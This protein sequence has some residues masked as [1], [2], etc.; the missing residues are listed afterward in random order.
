MVYSFTVVC[1]AVVQCIFVVVVAFA[2]S[3]ALYGMRTS[4]RALQQQLD[5]RFAVMLPL[6]CI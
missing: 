1:G 6:G 4:L 5:M 2:S 3:G